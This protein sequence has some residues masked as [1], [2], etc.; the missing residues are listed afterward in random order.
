MLFLL[1]R[2][3]KS[4]FYGWSWVHGKWA[5]YSRLPLRYQWWLRCKWRCR[6]WVLLLGIDVSYTKPSFIKCIV[7]NKIWYN[8]LSPPEAVLGGHN[9][10]D[11]ADQSDTWYIIPVPSITSLMTPSIRP[12]NYQSV[13]QSVSWWFVKS[14]KIYENISESLKSCESKNSFVSFKSYCI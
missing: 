9:T 3:T 12:F 2:C 5:A 10:V 6:S 14:R 7:S 13:S 11:G 4:V 8:L 1:W